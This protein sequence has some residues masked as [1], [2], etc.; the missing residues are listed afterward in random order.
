MST[1]VDPDTGR[2]IPPEEV[3][4]RG[5]KVV[6]FVPG[7]HKLPSRE[8][9]V[10]ARRGIYRKGGKSADTGLGDGV[11]WAV[12]GGLAGLVLANSLLD[13]DEESLRKMPGWKR[14]VRKWLIP[15]AATAAG[16]YGGYLL[17]GGGEK[18]A[19]D[20][21]KGE[22]GPTVYEAEREA[23]T[24]TP[25]P[26]Q[27]FATPLVTGG[28]GWVAGQRAKNNMKIVNDKPYVPYS[29]AEQGEMAARNQALAAENR[30]IARNKAMSTAEKA[31]RTFANNKEIGTN[32]AKM[33][34]GR[35]NP[36]A[37]KANAR[38]KGWKALQWL[39]YL[40]TTISTINAA[41]TADEYTLSQEDRERLRELMLAHGK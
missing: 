10:D 23:E 11:P 27:S 15:S 40:A 41:R 29:P 36:A 21:G 17:G 14:F 3:L 1:Y 6:K 24:P 4:R 38:A 28:A 39:S 35:P 8:D 25:F 33:T 2:V 20:N 16:A 19:Q 37:A 7:K 18:S 12:G 31:S 9:V 34:Q 5:I 22:Y 26:W 30:E 32:N 13:D